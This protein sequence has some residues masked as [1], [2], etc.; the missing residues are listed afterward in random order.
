MRKSVIILGLAL[1]G[2][3]N[4]SFASSSN[5]SDRNITAI[6]LREQSPLCN[7][8]VKGDFETVK[9]FIEY[10]AN[11]NESREGVTPLMLAAR[12]NNVQIVKYLLEKGARK[13]AKDERG[14]TA[15][16]YA[17]MSKATDALALLK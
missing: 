1:V 14:N 17:E 10:G 2:F 13:D 12:Y 9:K 5:V 11:V 16:K 8:I 7:A 15:E 6:V 4:V 3:A